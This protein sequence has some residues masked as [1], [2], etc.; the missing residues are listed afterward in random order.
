MSTEIIVAILSLIGTAVGSLAGIMTA[1]KLVLYR[2][3]QLEK[4]VAAHNNLIDR[5]YGAEKDIALVKDDLK[6]TNNRIDDLKK[7]GD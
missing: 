3:E 2:L 1:N 7:Q 4:K 5:M 6:A